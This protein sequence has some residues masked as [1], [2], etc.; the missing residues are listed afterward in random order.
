MSTNIASPLRLFKKNFDPHNIETLPP[1]R[2]AFVE[3]ALRQYGKDAKALGWKGSVADEMDLSDAEATAIA[4]VNSDCVDNVQ[5]V[6]DPRGVDLSVFKKNPVVPFGHDYSS[7]PVGTSIWQKIEREGARAYLLAKTKFRVM[8]D[9]PREV[10]ESMQDG[11]LRGW[12]IGFITLESGPPTDREM[13]KYPHWEG[14]ESIIR[15]WVNL[16]YSVVPVPC[17]AEALS[18]AVSKGVPTWLEDEW[19]EYL[20]SASGAAS[21]ME[22]VKEKIARTLAASRLDALPPWERR[23]HVAVMSGAPTT[24]PRAEAGEVE[25]R[26][27][28][29]VHALGTD[30]V[31]ALSAVEFPADGWTEGEAR[32]A[33]DAFGAALF[34]PLSQKKTTADLTSARMRSMLRVL[35]P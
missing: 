11:F 1:E 13:K 28:V 9:F 14:A 22:T 5:E 24:D 6:V 35:R 25:G 21:K 29:W 16:E 15:R 12:S 18:L 20:D 8:H 7:I 4:R 10:W 30:G 23:G 26:A 34:L 33:S 27:V 17:N 32:R 3:S 31:R 19:A 2:R